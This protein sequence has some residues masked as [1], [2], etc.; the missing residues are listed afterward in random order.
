[1]TK[2]QATEKR[3]CLYLMK[4][5]YKAF[6]S[7]KKKKSEKVSKSSVTVFSSGTIFCS[8]SFQHG[9]VKTELHSLKQIMFRFVVIEWATEWTYLGTGSRSNFSD[10]QANFHWLQITSGLRALDYKY[11]WS[12]FLY[13][14]GAVKD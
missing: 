14:V 10:F 11:S 8:L 4:S 12:V 13:E 1:M 2:S 3:S 5:Q 7:L 6:N 9:Q